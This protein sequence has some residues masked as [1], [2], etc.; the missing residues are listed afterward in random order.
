MTTAVEAVATKLKGPKDRTPLMTCH[1]YLIHER[2]IL[3][4]TPVTNRSTISDFY[5]ISIILMG[6][7]TRLKIL[8]SVTS[9]PTLNK[10]CMIVELI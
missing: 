4:N 5:N 6:S 7:N 10:K 2:H 1:N 8:W 3:I 9:R